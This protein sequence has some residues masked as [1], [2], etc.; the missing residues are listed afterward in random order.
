MPRVSEQSSCEN[1]KVTVHMI[2]YNHAKFIA[3]AIESVLMQETEFS[4]E[5]IIGEDCSTD[6]T[7][8]IVRRY[9]CQYPKFIRPLFPDQNLGANKNSR[10]VR[11]AW[12]GEYIAIL[13]GDDY[14]TDPRKLQKQVALMDQNPSYSMCGTAAQ[15]LVVSSDGQ[16]KQIGVYPSGPAKALY[17]LE[18]VLVEYPFWTVTFV[19]RNGIVNFPGWYEKAKYGDVC[20]LALYAEKGPVAYLNDVTATYR[21]HPGGIWS[22]GSISEKCKNCE[23]TFGLLNE[24]FA[25]RY[26]KLFRNR[27]MR[28]MI[29]NIPQAVLKGRGQ[30]AKQAYWKSFRRFALYRPVAFLKLGIAVYSDKYL[31]TWQWLITRIAIRTR[32]RRLVAL[33]AR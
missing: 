14:W 18:D 12:R 4:V 24:H 32:I 23:E 13:E 25:G 15:Q 11:E 2:T 10:A 7:R 1:P 17:S 22:G 20:L 9:A 29:Y 5:L 8:E 26:S 33:F 28:T 21:I 30:E 19:L 3:Q 6:G 27:E 16:D 31:P